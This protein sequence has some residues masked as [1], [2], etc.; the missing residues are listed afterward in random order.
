MSTFGKKALLNW[1]YNSGQT[2]RYFSTDKEL[3]LEILKKWY[4]VGEN[5]LYHNN[6]GKTTL[7]KE[8]RIVDYIFKHD[9]YYLLFF[10]K[11]NRHESSPMVLRPTKEFLRDIKLKEI[12]KDE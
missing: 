3:Q 2:L 4:P 6:L 11:D 1:N 10:N 9:S 12:L 8:V 7:V 5:F